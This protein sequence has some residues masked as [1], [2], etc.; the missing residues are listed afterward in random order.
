MHSVHGCRSS[1][2][3]LLRGAVL[4]LAAMGLVLWWRSS[5]KTVTLILALVVGLVLIPF[6]PERWD[7]RMRTMETYEQGRICDES[8]RFMDSGV[9]HSHRSNPGSGL[10]VSDPGGHRQILAFDGYL[11]GAQASTFRRW[12]N[13]ASSAPRPLS[14]FL[15]AGLEAMLVFT[16]AGAREILVKWAASM[17]SMMQASLVGY[18]I[19]RSLHQYRI[20][21]FALLS[22][23]RHCRDPVRINRRQISAADSL[24]VQPRRSSE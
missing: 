9:E 14:P 22:V 15:G 3:K 11:R 7:T 1:C 12:A 6:M 4:A 10:Q 5:Y 20:L 17:M 24:A 21:G 13:T 8:D 19:R 23:R 2:G 16:Q 18:A